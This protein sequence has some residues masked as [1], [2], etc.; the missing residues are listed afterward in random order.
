MEGLLERIQNA[1]K[2]NNIN[3]PKSL[4]AGL[5]QEGRPILGGFNYQIDQYLFLL[6][7]ETSRFAGQPSRDNRSV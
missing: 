2:D 7:T 6:I 3:T 1:V 4:T 5:P